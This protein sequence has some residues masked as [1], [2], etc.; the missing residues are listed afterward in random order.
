M[1]CSCFVLV[2]KPKEK[3]KEVARGFEDRWQMINCGG[4]IDGKHIRIVPP[5]LYYNY[6]HLYSVLSMAIVNSNYEFLYI[7]VG[8]RKDI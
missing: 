4:C 5:A 1:F 3:W 8:K 2:P 6:E 7:D